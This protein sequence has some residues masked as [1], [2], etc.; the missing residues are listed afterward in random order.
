MSDA[1]VLCQRVGSIAVIDCYS[2]FSITNANV[3]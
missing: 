1:E 2:L 3:N